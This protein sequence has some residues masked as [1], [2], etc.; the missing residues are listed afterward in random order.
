M[1]WKPVRRLMLILLCVQLAVPVSFASSS[2]AALPSEPAT[3]SGIE[4][5][6]STDAGMVLDLHFTQPTLAVVQM[7]SLIH[8]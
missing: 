6:E 2:R 8:I 5:I 1:S 7:L 4:I 3:A